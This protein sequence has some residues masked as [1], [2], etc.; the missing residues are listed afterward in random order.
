MPIVIPSSPTANPTGIS[1]SAL[2][3][4][5]EYAAIEMGGEGVGG[6]LASAVTGGSTSVLTDN[7]W[8]ANT[9]L[10]VAEQWQ[11]AWLFRPNA[12]LSTDKLR[13]V[14]VYTPTG[15]M[16]QPDLNWLNAPA[17]GERY[18]I[19][20]VVEP[21]T[22]LLRCINFGLRRC[23]IE[24]EFSFVPIGGA[25]W[26]SLA[27]VAPWLTDKSWVRQVGYLSN[28]EDRNSVWPYERVIRGEAFE[29][30]GTVI[31][32]H[33]ENSF[34]AH[35][36][37][38][39]FIIYVRAMAPAYSLCMAQAHNYGN[40]TS[41]T[42][43]GTSWTITIPSTVGMVRGQAVTL[44]NFTPSTYNTTGIILD[45]PSA[46]TFSIEAISQPATPSVFGSVTAT[47]QQSGLNLETD[48]APIPVEWA[49]WAAIIEAWR[50]YGQVLDTQARLRLIPNRVEAAAIFTDYTRTY[51]K[52]PKLTFRPLLVGGPVRIG[53]GGM[54]IAYRAT[55]A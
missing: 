41:V 32:S 8:P 20:T 10:D 47:S 5:R 14:S 38:S 25:R 50:H 35:G 27:Q 39:P 22:A 13:L 55:T 11:D 34:G 33:P 49:G 45:I 36:Q 3:Q 19:H 6:Y 24:T 21:A 12:V 16:F 54:P 7:N 9:T 44:A 53:I 31:L 28:T 18:E 40:A 4:I 23:F 1:P 52:W 29:E 2:Q 15:G 42:T 43:N 51:S 30:A 48:L 37:A 46:T 26:H 17:E